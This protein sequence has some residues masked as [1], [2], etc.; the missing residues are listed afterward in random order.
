MYKIY[1]TNPLTNECYFQD[2]NELT[3]ALA[4]VNKCRVDG[5]I[6]VTLVSE[7]PNSI[8]L[9]GAEVIVNG[10]L[11]NGLDYTWKKRR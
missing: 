4:V 7:N 11:P 3:I 9:P 5:M 6:F 2:E 1:Y 8:G 10:K